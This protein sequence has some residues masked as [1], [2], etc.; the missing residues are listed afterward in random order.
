MQGNGEKGNGKDNGERLAPLS[1]GDKKVPNGVR[2]HILDVWVD[3]LSGVSGEDGIEE[4]IGEVL[5]EPVRTL[6]REGRE[7]IVRGRARDV[8]GDERV[9]GLIGE[10]TENGLEE[11]GGNE[12]WD[13]FED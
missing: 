9:K 1:A 12:E 5:M 13:G 7:K 6:E 8:L 4:K 11:E 2:Y 10:R 3:E